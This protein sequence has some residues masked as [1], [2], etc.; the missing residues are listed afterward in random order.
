M[1]FQAEI[2][3]KALSRKGLCEKHIFFLSLIYNRAQAHTRTR[4]YIYLII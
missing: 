4:L 3:L 2:A 1:G